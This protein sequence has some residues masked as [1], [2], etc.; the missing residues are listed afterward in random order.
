MTNACPVPQCTP[1]I[2]RNYFVNISGSAFAGVVDSSDCSK[3][4]LL[5]TDDPGLID[6]GD[7]GLGDFMSADDR[8]KLIPTFEEAARHFDPQSSTYRDLQCFFGLPIG[9]GS[10]SSFIYLGYVDRDGGETLTQGFQEIIKC[11]TCFW[12]VVPTM[13]QNDGT[14]LY[15]DT[16]EMLDLQSFIRTDKDFDIK[17]PTIEASVIFSDVFETA[18]QAATAALAGSDAEYI[19]SSYYCDVQRLP[20]GDPFINP[21]VGDPEHNPNYPE[22]E[23]IPEFRFSN[24]ALLIGAVASSYSAVQDANYNWTEFL[25][26]FNFGSA[27]CATGRFLDE[28]T[29]GLP[30]PPQQLVVTETEV[31]NATG[32]NGFDGSFVSG[33][34]RSVSLFANSQSGVTYVESL[35]VDRSQFADAWYKEKAIND[36][37]EQ[38]VLNFM[39]GRQSLG[40]SSKEQRQLASRIA[41]VLQSFVDKQVIN[42]AEYDWEANGYSN[43]IIDRDGFVVTVR[44]ISE[45]PAAAITE[46]NGY[47]VG[48]CY[49]INEPQHRVGINIC[50]FGVDLSQVGV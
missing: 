20:N 9:R 28:T 27:S 12:T 45:V 13:Y 18:S 40:L 47:I 33:A 8:L 46:R 36:A 3:G 48:A 25:K 15:A 31:T 23:T 50:E 43:I 32:I 29:L 26:P 16:V 42:P 17:V 11:P 38:E 2:K 22:G 39:A 10:R 24:D 6:V 4:L 41:I 44:P 37:L 1:V 49:I 7:P 19:V 35:R 21:P 34:E 30:T 5:L 14:T